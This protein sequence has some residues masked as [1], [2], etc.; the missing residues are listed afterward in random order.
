M[1]A[2]TLEVK[3]NLD[4]LIVWYYLI[5]PECWRRKADIVPPYEEL[6]SKRS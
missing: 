2:V 4:L 3:S 1:Y 5:S 6:D